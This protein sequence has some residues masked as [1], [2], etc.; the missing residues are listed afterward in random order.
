MRPSISEEIEKYD[1]I[2]SE[3]KTG[4]DATG[5]PCIDELSPFGLS[6]TFCAVSVPLLMANLD[7]KKTRIEKRAEGTFR[8]KYHLSK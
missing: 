1:R 5:G 7:A 4:V 6:S 8:V 2:D 3:E